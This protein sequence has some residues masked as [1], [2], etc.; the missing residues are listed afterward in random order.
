[1]KLYFEEPTSAAIKAGIFI[2]V[3]QSTLP[4]KIVQVPKIFFSKVRL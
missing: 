4:N 3:R 2:M 1:M